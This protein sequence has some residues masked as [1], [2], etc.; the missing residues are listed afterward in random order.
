MLTRREICLRLFQILVGGG[1]L[2]LTW[3]YVQGV[4][5][6]FLEISFPGPPEKGEVLHRN[7][8]YFLNLEQGLKLFSARC[9]HL[10]C[11]LEFNSKKK[12]F[13]CPCHGS[14]FSTQGR[15]IQGPAKKDMADLDFR[16]DNKEGGYKVLLPFS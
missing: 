12:R 4:G 8:V 7:G 5:G 9:P 1:F 14:I 13:Q 10:G 15:C 3:K 2:H 6:S 16:L 11:R